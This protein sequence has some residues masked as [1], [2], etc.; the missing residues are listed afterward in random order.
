MRI[1]HVVSTYPPYHGGMGNVAQGMAQGLRE[2]G[3]HCDVLT[4]DYGGKVALEAGV[5]RLRPW[6]S[7]RN[8]AFVPSLASRLKAGK[9]DL[10]HL[11]YPFLGGAES[12]FWFK[13][14]NPNTRLIITYHMD[15]FGRGWRRA[16]LSLYRRLFMRRMMRQ[17]DVVTCSSL[18]YAKH[19]ALAAL[20]DLHLVELAFG[21]VD[22][23]QPQ[24]KTP[25]VADKL[26]L[27][28]VG[29]LDQ[30]HYFKGLSVLF[31][32]LVALDRIERSKLRLNIVGDGDL[33]PIYEKSVKDLGLQEQ[34][35]F[36]G[37]LGASALVRAYQQADMT[38]L[39]SIDQSEAFGLVLLESMAC[40]TP[41]IASDLPGVRTVLERERT[42][43]LV[44]PND[45][46]DL[47]ERLS[48]CL[49]RLKLVREMR[50]ASAKRVQDRYRWPHIIEQLESLY[51]NA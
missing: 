35:F 25:A 48:F 4:P 27:L 3:H 30:A 44:Q 22:R 16:V 1:A 26:T 15:T 32:S 50:G 43:F 42:G 36:S 11:H 12:V 41:V 38:V 40:G 8:A 31:A 14:R 29:G 49:R 10:V 37:K 34:V 20:P 46:K 13:L 23:F 2:R 18:D 21:V 19:S 45:A 5:I 28:F 33:R 7:S 47:A 39:P 17:A 24:D 6:F 51:R 9:Y